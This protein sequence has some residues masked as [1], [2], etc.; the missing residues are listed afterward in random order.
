ML[1]IN[2]LI[3][4]YHSKLAEMR[5]SQLNG[6]NRGKEDCV[7]NKTRKI[8]ELCCMRCLS[9]AFKLNS[10][11]GGSLSVCLPVCLS[12]IP[13]NTYTNACCSFIFVLVCSE[14]W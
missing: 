5:C 2:T 9:N 4:H 12:L 6:A 1:N 14:E 7:N 8:T 11:F 10:C 3:K 13:I